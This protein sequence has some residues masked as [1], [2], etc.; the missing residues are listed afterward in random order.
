VEGES[1]RLHGLVIAPDGSQSVAGDRTGSAQAPEELG[2][3]LAADLLARGAR[4]LLD[5]HE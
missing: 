5:G 1:L 3:S 4:T 2:A